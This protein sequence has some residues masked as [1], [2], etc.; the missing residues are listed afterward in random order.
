MSDSPE[1][2]GNKERSQLRMSAMNLLA[3]REHSLHELQQKLSARYPNS[4]MI[5]AVLDKLQQ[6]DLQSDRRFADAFFRDRY[7]KGLGAYRIRR[8][9][10]QRGVAERVIDEVFAEQQT[11]WFELA[12]DLAVRRFGESPASDFKERSKRARFLQYRGFDNEQINY[13]LDGKL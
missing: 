7:R 9:L 6:Q 11:D 2:A 10:Q 1:S 5:S 12:R 4:D 13:A 3:R 8:E